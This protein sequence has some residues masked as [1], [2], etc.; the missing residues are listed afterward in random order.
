MSSIKEVLLLFKSEL[1]LHYDS[2][3]AV[4]IAKLALESVMGFSTSKM[5]AFPETRLADHQSAEIYQLLAE[6]KTGKPIQYIIGHT[7]FFGLKF[8]VNSNVLIPRPETEELVDW[9][10]ESLSIGHQAKGNLLDIGTGSGCIAISLKKNLPEIEVTA[11][12]ISPGALQTA[13]ENAIFNQTAIN[14]LEVDILNNKASV[15]LPKFKVIISNPPYVTQLDK[16]QM[17]QN[18]TD[19]EPHT[20][21]FVPEQDPLLFYRV[22]ADFSLTHLEPKCLLFFEINEAFGEQIVQL[23]RDRGFSNIELK[24]D[25]SGRDRMIK[26]TQTP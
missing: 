9:V 11:I 5:M 14:F 24:Q 12:D 7:E 16:K 17:H 23:L 15:S 1:S 26:A 19:F 13:K 2:N 22:I 21:L 3:E 4:S 25:L 20:A 18:V 10:I 6:L 8:S